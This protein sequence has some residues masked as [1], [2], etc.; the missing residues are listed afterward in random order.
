MIDSAAAPSGRTVQDSGRLSRNRN[1]IVKPFNVTFR[2]ALALAIVCS[3]RTCSSNQGKT[4]FR[5]MHILTSSA[6]SDINI[7]NMALHPFLRGDFPNVDLFGVELLDRH[8]QLF[9]LTNGHG[10][11]R[12]WY[13][14]A[15][16]SYPTQRKT[17]LHSFL[18]WP[19]PPMVVPHLS[20]R[21]TNTI[22]TGQ[23]L[24]SQRY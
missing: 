7:L 5:S 18:Y 3:A 16:Y 10:L 17:Q 4:K 22:T 21:L 20:E 2:S 9:V 11:H 19:E 23:A 6:L 12:R 24:P 14:Y 15:L 1:F 8:H 13:R